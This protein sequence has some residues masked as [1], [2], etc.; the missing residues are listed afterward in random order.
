MPAIKYK[1]KNGQWQMLNQVMVNQ[2]NVVQTTGSSSADVMSQSAVTEALQNVH[3]DVDQTLDSTT[4][5]S[6]NPVASKAVY[7]AITNSKEVD[8]SSGVTPT[9][10]N[11][12]LWIDESEDPF[13]MDNF[14]SSSAVTAMTGY[15][16][17]ASGS[18]VSTS[19]TLNEAIA[20]LEK[21]IADLEAQIAQKENAQTVQQV[22]GK[23]YYEII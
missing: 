8:I 2:I 22:Q 13:E 7:S 5:A 18:S 21:R 16:I 14:R 23:D 17:A 19:D 4:S 15:V 6:T 20:K 10:E 12:E 1:D 11:I 3:I 9:D